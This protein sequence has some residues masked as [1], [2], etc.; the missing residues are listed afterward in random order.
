VVNGLAMTCELPIGHSWEGPK[1]ATGAYGNCCKQAHTVYVANNFNFNIVG[2]A[3]GRKAYGGVG[4]W[5]DF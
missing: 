1:T 2:S 4:V 5:E 3:V